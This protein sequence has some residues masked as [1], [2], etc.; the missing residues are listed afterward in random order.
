MIYLKKLC[1]KDHLFF[2]LSNFLWVVLIIEYPIILICRTIVPGSYQFLMGNS[3]CR[4]GSTQN[5]SFHASESILTK[6][7]HGITTKLQEIVNLKGMPW[8]L[9]R[10]I[11]MLTTFYSIENKYLTKS[12]F[13]KLN[14]VWILLTKAINNYILNKNFNSCIISKSFANQKYFYSFH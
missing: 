5:L 11:H 3:I 10:C 13:S 9:N 4:M 7:I 8:Q 14:L 12:Q 2:G 1:S 6:Q